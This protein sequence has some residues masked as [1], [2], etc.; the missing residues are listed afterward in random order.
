M[1]RKQRL[2]VILEAIRGE[3]PEVTRM[4]TVVTPTGD[5][6][7]EEEEEEENII[8]ND[9]RKSMNRVNKI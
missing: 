2:T 8:F 3:E 6:E 1:N 4:Q 5:D 7:E 9:K